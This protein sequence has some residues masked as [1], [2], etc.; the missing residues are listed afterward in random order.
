MPGQRETISCDD[1]ST[2]REQPASPG[3]KGVIPEGHRLMHILTIDKYLD[4]GAGS[5]HEDFHAQDVAESDELRPSV[6]W[7]AEVPPVVGV[8]VEVERIV[9]TIPKNT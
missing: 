3:E 6:E 4:P 2:R 9:C 1:V 8:E 7:V 5:A